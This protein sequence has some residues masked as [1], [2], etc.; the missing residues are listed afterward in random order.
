MA[1]STTMESSSTWVVIAALAG[2]AAVAVIKFFAAFLSGSA[3]LMSEGIHS[4]VDTADQGLLLYGLRRARKP[5]DEAFPFGYGKEVY[6]WSFVVATQLFSIGALASIYEGVLHIL[7]QSA[8]EDATLG[9]IV[10][11]LAFV[12]EASSWSFAVFNFSRSKGRRSYVEAIRVA[13]DPTVFVVLFE[14]SAALLGIVIA[15]LGIFLSRKTGIPWFD[16][17][18]SI[19]IGVILGVTAILLAREVKGL[20][21]G[22][23]ANRPVVKGIRELAA[24]FPEIRAVN[25]ALT[26][27]VGPNF[28]LVNLSV[29]FAEQLNAGEVASAAAHLDVAIKE[30]YPRVKRVFIEAKTAFLARS[31]RTRTE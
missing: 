26:M 6:F 19:L 8:I 15:F 20:L 18:A 13:K 12:F 10:L 23:S 7:H 27:H 28:I 30:R 14:D 1:R 2:N 16:G 31:V 29:A 3:A 9:Y 25:E 21:I 24:S 5:A 11:G 22:E 17:V 4:L